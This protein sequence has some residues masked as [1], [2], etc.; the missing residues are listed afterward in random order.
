MKKILFILSLLA[1]SCMVYAQ[2][3]SG[4][5]ETRAERNAEFN[6]RP[7]KDKMAYGGELTLYFSNVSLFYISPF[8]GYRFNPDLTLGAG[9]IYQYMS[10]RNG[11]GQGTGTV[12]RDHVF[13]GRA[14]LRHELGRLFFAHAEYEILNFKH[15]SQ[16]GGYARRFVDIASLGLGYKNSSGGDF[17]Y[18]YIMV[19]FDFI[20]NPNIAFVYPTAPIIFKMGFIFGK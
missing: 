20:Q 12:Y 17:G 7:L 6:E 16:I 8:A 18:Y 5:G 4:D 1:F 14:F 11:Y 13:G 10:I 15:Y 3:N 19:L 2:N 9:P